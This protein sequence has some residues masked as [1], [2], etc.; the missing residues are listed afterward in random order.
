M[1]AFRRRRPDGPRRSLPPLRRRCASDRPSAAP[2]TGSTRPAPART[3][4]R[5][6][7]EE[8]WEYGRGCPCG[9]GWAP[10]REIRTARSGWASSARC[11]AGTADGGPAAPKDRHASVPQGGRRRPA[12]SPSAGGARGTGRPA[13]RSGGCRA[14]VS[15][16]PGTAL[17]SVRRRRGRRPF[18]SG[19]CRR[20]SAWGD[21]PRSAVFPRHGEAR[22]APLGGASSWAARKRPR[23]P[24]SSPALLCRTALWLVCVQDRYAGPWWQ[25]CT[26][27]GRS[28]RVSLRV[29]DPAEIGG[30]PLEARLG[31]GAWV[32]C[33]WPVRVRGGL[34]RSS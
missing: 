8:G 25:R 16:G 9:G 19:P 22:R 15:D 33:S 31:S 24:R 20:G 7:V 34:S 17:D 29:G 21:G 2:S 5:S 4:R 30:Y 1:P 6:Q 32:R 28:G 27:D 23:P 14:V 10:T 26:G 11:G 13:G 12:G 3:G 18:C